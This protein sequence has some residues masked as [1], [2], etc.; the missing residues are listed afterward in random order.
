MLERKG[1]RDMAYGASWNASHDPEGQ[2][3][4]GNAAYSYIQ[5]T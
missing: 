5:L 4:I 1:W 3:K 2:A